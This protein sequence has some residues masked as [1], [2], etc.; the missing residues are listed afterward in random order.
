MEFLNALTFG[1]IVA[2]I[3]LTLVLLTGLFVLRL[4]LRLTATLV[5]LGC[6]LIL[7]IVIGTAIF[8]FVN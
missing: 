2:L 6:F 3:V 4:V 5:R 8:F 7:L 1:D